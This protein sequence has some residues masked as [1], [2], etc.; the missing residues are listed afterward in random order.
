M[1]PAR[2]IVLTDTMAI[3]I[4]HDLG[5][6]NAIRQR[7]QLHSVPRCVEEATRKNKDGAVLVN[8]KPDELAA[9]LTLGNPDKVATLSLTLKIGSQADLND[10]ERDLLA[11]A[12]TL[13]GAWFLC[14]PDNG[15]VRAMQILTLL[16]RMVSLEALAGDAGHRFKNPLPNHFTERWLSDHR[17]R[18]LFDMI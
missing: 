18:G 10:G 15:T 8:R 6:W 12:R 9:E 5:C 2:S 4:A 7:Y 11:Y 17:T 3:K 13:P 14:G 1:V 16:D